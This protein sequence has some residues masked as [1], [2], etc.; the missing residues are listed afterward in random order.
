MIIRELLEEDMLQA[1]EL[2]SLCW[3]EEVGIAS[4]M[5]LNIE[6]E[7]AF[8]TNFTA[9]LARTLFVKKHRQ[10]TTCPLTYIN[11]TSHL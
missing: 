9:D 4:D 3:P 10:R 5:G 7:Y 6:K 8:W 11:A 1:I 2:K